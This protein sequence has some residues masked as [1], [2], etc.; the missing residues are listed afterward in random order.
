MLRGRECREGNWGS[1]WSWECVVLGFGLSAGGDPCW[2]RLEIGERRQGGTTAVIWGRGGSETRAKDSGVGI[3][4]APEKGKAE[5][6]SGE[7]RA[8]QKCIEGR[9]G[10]T[11]TKRK[12][13][14]TPGFVGFACKDLRTS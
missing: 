10:R 8:V 9:G 7:G 1:F 12:G 4:K 5:G 2:G 13:K 11:R 14:S 6:N 3:E